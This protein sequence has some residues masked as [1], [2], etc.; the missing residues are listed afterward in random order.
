M[1]LANLAVRENDIRQQRVYGGAITH[2]TV[3]WSRLFSW[4]A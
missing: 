3:Q 2:A 1:M 4:K